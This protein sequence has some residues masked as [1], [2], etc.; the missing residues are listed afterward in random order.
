MASEKQR[1]AYLALRPDTRQDGIGETYQDERFAG[2]DVFD[3]WLAIGGSYRYSFVSRIDGEVW[4]V[5]T[6]ERQGRGTAFQLGCPVS[7][8]EGRVRRV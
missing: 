2:G 7:R 3:P 6:A 5:F 8:P 4:H 1:A